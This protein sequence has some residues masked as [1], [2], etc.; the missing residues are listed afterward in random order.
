[1]K[2]SFVMLAICLSIFT[3]AALSQVSY[4]ISYQGYLSSAGGLP[5]H[6][7]SY[8]LTFKLYDV[9]SGGSALWT[10]NHSSVATA[11][12]TFIVIL[13]SITQLAGV[14]F[15]QQLW[16]GITKGNDPE[17][18]PRSRIT[19][20]PSAL[21]PWSAYNGT[22]SYLKGNVGIGT[23]S[24]SALLQLY[25]GTYNTRLDG[26]NILFSR[27]DGPAY[28]D[29]ESIGGSIDFV[30]NG[31]SPGDLSSNLVLSSN[32][33]SYFNGNLGVGNTNPTYKMHVVD[34]GAA[35][36]RVQ[37]NS[38]GGAVA[39]FGG[40]GAFLIDAVN[41][42]GGR[43]TVQDTG[44]VGIGTPTPAAKLHV[45]STTNN[46]TAEIENLLVTSY[47][48]ALKVTSALNAGP[49]FNT[50]VYG[51]ASST[52]NY[53]FGVEGIA[54]GTG[55]SINYGIYGQAALG[56]T[57]YAG[58]YGGDLAYTG[59][60]VHASDGKF[61]EN[62]RNFSGALSQIMSLTPRTFDYK[63]GPEYKRFS[64][65]PGKHFGFVAQEVESVIPELVV[66]AVQPPERNTEGHPGGEPVQYK[67]LKSIEM[68]PILV[69]AMQEQQ[70]LIE[71]LRREVAELKKK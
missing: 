24:P 66:T 7:S 36:L 23:S 69:A 12:G 61:K 4:T 29:A 27:S 56:S 67:A 46:P 33:N 17:F 34:Q 6:D 53:N 9:Q 70:K 18:S 31:R 49:F 26:N 63:S 57:N 1:M 71:D 38:T 8:S 37:T 39:S 25:N 22:L 59:S 44:N 35:G 51:Q 10:E 28:I 50:A 13:G 62:V 5:V 19:S 40:N 14:D 21:A 47:P 55:T 16:M 3:T 30:T 2:Q 42:V 54:N 15:N 32:Q 41:I 64:F 48:I 43:L 65:S 60:L 52:A 20:A 45:V 68:I 58:Y 11:K